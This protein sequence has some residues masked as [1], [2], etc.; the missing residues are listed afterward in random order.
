MTSPAPI[1][2]VGLT[3]GTPIIEF[4]GISKRFGG[5]QALDDVSFAVPSAEI[6]ALVG[7]NG[8]G[9]STLIRICGGVFAPDAG[10]IKFQGKEVRFRNVDESHDA[11]ISIVHQE[12]PICPHLTAAE[13]IFLGRQLPKKA[14]LIDWGE[15]NRRTRALFAQLGVTINPQA[16]ASDLTIAQQQTVVIAQALA[17]FAPLPIKCR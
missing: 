10:T 14:G 15:V 6:H 4:A 11:G 8:A 3:Q 5:V 17:H 13:N 1:N 16:L 12:I 2:P 9:K 7:E